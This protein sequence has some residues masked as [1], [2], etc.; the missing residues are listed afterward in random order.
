MQDWHLRA[1]FVNRVGLQS[2][3]ACIVHVF[4]VEGTVLSRYGYVHVFQH[5]VGIMT[6]MCLVGDIFS[7]YDQPVFIDNT[8]QLSA[9]Y[10]TTEIDRGLYWHSDVDKARRRLTNLTRQCIKPIPC[11]Q[12]VCKPCYNYPTST[13]SY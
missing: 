9:V 12:L 1:A 4:S 13:W 3:A 5:K 2:A 10:L 7:V 11:P 6:V 8:N